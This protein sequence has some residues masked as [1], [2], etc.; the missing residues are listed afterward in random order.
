MHG[1]APIGGVQA[2]IG[3]DSATM[4]RRRVSTAL[5][6]GGWAVALAVTVFA[7]AALLTG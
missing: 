2:L 4:G 7:V 5:A 1:P 6:V 3:R